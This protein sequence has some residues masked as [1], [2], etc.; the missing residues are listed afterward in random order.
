MWPEPD[1]DH[2]LHDLE[3]GALRVV[4]RVQEREEPRAPV[5]LEPDRGRAERAGDHERGAQRARRRAGDEQH[6]GE[7]HEQRDR[8]AHVGLED[9]QT[10][11][12]RR[13]RADRPPELAQVAGRLPVRE[14]RRRPD[15]EREL[16]EL[17]RLEDGR[18][19]RDPAA[20][21]VDRRPDHEHGGEQ[22]ERDEHER[23]APAPGAAGSPSAARATISPIPSAA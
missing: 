8:R 22:P 5:R 11:E 6:A 10:A 2:R 16:R 12:E 7:H 9:Q 13:E 17:R 15:R 14:V 18:P 4:P 23:R 3:A 1:A 19:E 20:R 21:A